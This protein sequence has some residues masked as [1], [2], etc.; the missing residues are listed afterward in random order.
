MSQF[1]DILQSARVGRP[2]Q[3]RGISSPT[4]F[5]LKSFLPLQFF[6]SFCLSQGRMQG[7]VGWAVRSRLQFL[8]Q[9]EWVRPPLP[10]PPHSRLTGFPRNRRQFPPSDEI[11]SI[12]WWNGSQGELMFWCWWWRVWLE[13]RSQGWRE[14]VATH[15]GETISWLPARPLSL[16]AGLTL[17]SNIG[18]WHHWG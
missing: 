5:S 6:K 3:G 9:L 2:V 11:N 8:N 4:D 17:H 1:S 18:K 7:G 12:C 16:I 10:S 13:W 14:G 15:S